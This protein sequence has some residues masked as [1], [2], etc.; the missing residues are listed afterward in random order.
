MIGT[1]IHHSV[2]DCVEV[3]FAH[4]GLDP[5]DF[6]RVDPALIR[7]AEVDSLLAD[8]TKAREE[9]DWSAKTSFTELIELMVEADLARQ[10]SQSGSRRGKGRAR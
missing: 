1:G 7:P 3:A 8:P 4:V 6:V 10:E 5:S 9:L 2:R